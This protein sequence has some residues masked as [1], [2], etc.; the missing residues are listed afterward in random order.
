MFFLINVF[1]LYFFQLFGMVL[2]GFGIWL[3]ADQSSVVTLLKLAEHETIRVLL[4]QLVIETII[5][6][7]L[8]ASDLCNV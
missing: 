3:V 5:V 4:L 7:Y 8:N 1:C 2:L 6:V